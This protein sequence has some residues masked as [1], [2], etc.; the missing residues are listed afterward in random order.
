MQGMRQTTQMGQQQVLS[1]QMRQ[2]LEIL[3][4][5]A[6]ELEQMVRLELETN[7]ALELE[8]PGVEDAGTDMDELRWLNEE[9]SLAGDGGSSGEDED[10]R[11]K[12]FLEGVSPPETL[13]QHLE[14]QMGRMAL[15][16]EQRRIATLLAGNLDEDGYL[17]ASPDEVAAEAAVRTDDVLK[18]LKMLQ[19]LEPAGVGARD[20]SECLLLQ[21]ARRNEGD[22][23][24]ARLAADHLD[25]LGGRKFAEIAA[26][27]GV[28][29][30]EA[31][32]AGALIAR[33]N[34]KPGRAFA[35]EVARVLVPDVLIE[36]DGD[37]F[38]VSPAADSVPRLRISRAC[39]DLL[40]RGDSPPEVRDYLREKIRGG[41]FFIKSIQQ[42]QQTVLAIAREIASRQRAFFDRGVSGLVPMTM[43]QV[44]EA[45]GVHETTVG[46][47][48]AGKN[49]STP[50]GVFEMKSF[51]THG[52]R[53]DEGGAV[54]NASVKDAIATLIRSEDAGR[55]LSD[56]QIVERLRGEGLSVAR[57]TVAKYREAL[58]ILPSHLRKSF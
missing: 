9:W 20:L 35:G 30:G 32:E 3:Q 5:A 52:Y 8:Q 4:A 24:A 47:A 41:K 18:V 13:A 26:A 34:P 15:D 51:F 1:P 43:A 11:R 42:R 23:T 19:S 46:R 36:R 2:S 54:S 14:R 38:A 28:S 37:D 55:P 56:Q 58:G 21:L 31:R 48:I 39:R 22:G 40:G 17:A 53:G 45:L 44:A 6:P 16:P 12:G 27:L 49:V 57:R 7:P 50:R 10:E 33:L 29:E 25:L